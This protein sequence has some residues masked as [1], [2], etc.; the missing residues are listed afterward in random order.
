MIPWLTAD[1]AFP[2]IDKALKEPK[3][4]NGLL[5]IGGD[6]SPARLLAAYRQGI[7]PWYSDGDPLLW[8]SPD[9]RM[10][11]FPSEIRITRSLAKILRNADYTV[12]LD[13]AF[14]QVIAACAATPRDGQN[15]TWI[16]AEMQ[17]AYTR[18]HALGHAHSVE[19]WRDGRL[20]GGLYGIAIGRAFFGES[21]FSHVTDASKIALAHLCRYLA[22][23]DFGIIDCQMETAHLASM[24]ARPIPRS[25]YLARVTALVDD[26]N[27]PGRW[28]AD[29]ID[30]VFR[31][32]QPLSERSAQKD[33]PAGG[34]GLGGGDV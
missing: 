3:G 12:R 30:G 29:G 14:A 10:V 16:T 5:A 24:G 20:V 1:L 17:Q 15:G 27:R 19:T 33:S 25:E 13:T 11:L 6:L 31:K 26:G 2:P 8:W 22:A 7:F 32:P 28:P 18:L 23:R 4:P 34:R 9:P 21:M